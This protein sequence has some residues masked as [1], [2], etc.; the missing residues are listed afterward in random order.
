MNERIRELWSQAGGHYNGGNQHTWPEYT[1]TDPE[2]FAELIVRECAELS[3]NSQYA[4]TKN[5]YYEG[6]NEALVYAG[7]KIRKHFGVEE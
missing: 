5:E 3:V 6:F 7:N 1:I 2:K 4:N